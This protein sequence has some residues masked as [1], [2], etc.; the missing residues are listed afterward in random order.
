[1]LAV[2]RDS[3]FC[4]LANSFET[5]A[6]EK[7]WN[8]ESKVMREGL[9]RN[10]IESWQSIGNRWRAFTAMIQKPRIWF[11]PPMRFEKFEKRGCRQSRNFNF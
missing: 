10:S 5:P 3:G 4:S 8:Y 11:K 6:K 9:V 2:V 1:V 7:E